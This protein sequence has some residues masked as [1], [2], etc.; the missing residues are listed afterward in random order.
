MLLLVLG[1]GCDDGDK[2]S[3]RPTTNLPP[4]PS[5]LADGKKAARVPLALRRF[6][7]RPVLGARELPEQSVPLS[8]SCRGAGARAKFSTAWVSTEGLT[9]SYAIAGTVA[10]AC[11]AAMIDGRWMLCGGGSAR[12]RI[13]R[14][15]ELAGGGLNLCVPRREKSRFGPFMWIAVPAETHWVLVDHHTHWVAYRVVGGRLL[16]ISGLRR[17]REFRVNVAFFDRSGRVQS[18]REARGYVAG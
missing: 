1:V 10:F 6:K 3:P 11:E 16:R 5:T 17:A 9:V 14:R 4:V 2:T 7:D 13:P 8:P 12:S 18:E 15:V